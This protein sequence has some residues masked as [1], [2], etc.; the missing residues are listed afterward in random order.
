MT[1]R[2]K[3]VNLSACRT[4]EVA[5]RDL[6]RELVEDRNRGSGEVF[7]AVFAENDDL[8]AFDKTLI[9]GRQPG[10][11]GEWLLD[12]FQ[13]NRLH[14]VIPNPTTF[15]AWMMA[16]LPWKLLRWSKGEKRD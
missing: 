5:A 7:A 4:D 12:A 8:V 15:L 9:A 13:D 10:G 6:Y 11:E 2:P 1:T 14:D 16:D 3:D